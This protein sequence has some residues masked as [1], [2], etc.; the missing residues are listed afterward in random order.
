MGLFD[1]FRKKQEQPEDAA[2]KMG[3]PE[4]GKPETDQRERGQV[5]ADQQESAASKMGQPEAGKPETDQHERGQLDTDQQETAAPKM[6]QP[7]I[8]K[9]DTDQH[10]RGQL[11]IDQQEAAHEKYLGDLEKTHLIFNLIKVPVEE[12]DEEWQHSFLENIVQASFRC[13][14]PQVITGP[15]GFPYF[16]LLMPNPN[17]SFQCYVIEQMKDDFL[18]ELGYGVVINPQGGNPDWV[19]TYGDITNLDL[20]GSFYTS[21]PTPFSTFKEDE[22][23]DGD[24]KVMVGQPSDIIL[25]DSNRA[26]LRAYLNY[27]GIMSPKIFLMFRTGKN[28]EVSQELVFNLTPA[29]FEDEEVFRYVMQNLAWFL[30]RHYSFVGM[31]E[32]SFKDSFM[33]L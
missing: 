6:G 17:E 4:N 33:P 32:E 24:E 2:P 13:G 23:I 10:E 25:S 22:T 29:D 16:Q 21:G 15:D 26:V 9:S 3:Q 30:P 11:D 18:L 5:E 12:R 1:L 31:D 28:G 27:N 8:G 20:N 7:E 14:E 19:L